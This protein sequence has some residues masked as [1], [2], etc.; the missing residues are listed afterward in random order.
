MCTRISRIITR[1]RSP[2]IQTAFAIDSNLPL[3]NCSSLNQQALR[4]HERGTIKEDR[5]NATCP[6]VVHIRMMNSVG[7]A[8]WRPLI[9]ATSV[10][11]SNC[12]SKLG[13]LRKPMF[14]SD[15]ATSSSSKT[16][17]KNR[18]WRSTTPATPTIARGHSGHG[19]SRNARQHTHA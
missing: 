1:L 13:T 8:G 6:T 11:T 10:P 17:Y 14:G 3:L 16:A 4:Y 18:Y 7:L 12:L 5:Y 2:S 9:M 19:C 15:S